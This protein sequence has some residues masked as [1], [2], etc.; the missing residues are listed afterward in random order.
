MNKRKG[1]FSK[2]FY[3]IGITLLPIPPL[4]KGKL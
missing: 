1:T 3:G 2:T 4:Q